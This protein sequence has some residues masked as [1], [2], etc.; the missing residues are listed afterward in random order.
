MHPVLLKFPYNNTPA[1]TCSGPNCPII[2]EYKIVQK[3]CFRFP[4][5]SEQFLADVL[6]NFVFPDDGPLLPEKSRS[7]NKILWIRWFEL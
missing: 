6:Y 3:N 5:C 7:F 1:T 2:R 4:S